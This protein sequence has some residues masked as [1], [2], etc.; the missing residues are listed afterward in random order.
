MEHH[1]FVVSGPAGVG[2]GTLV[3]MLIERNRDIVASVSCTTRSPRAGEIDGIHY[4][5]LTKEAFEQRI[6]EDGFLEYDNHFGNYYGTPK[7]FVLEQ[8][9]HK[10]VLLE[11]DVN[12]ALNVKRAFPDAQLIFIAPPSLEELKHR[13]IGRNSETEETL[14]TRLA[15]VEYEYSLQDRYDYV[16]VNDT[17]ESAYETLYNIIHQKG[18]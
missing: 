8:L 15:R 16:V 13:L 18:V 10:N 9:Q 7:A 14:K 2:K 1:L 12:G 3:S 6:S 5:F 11:I 17:L 4:F